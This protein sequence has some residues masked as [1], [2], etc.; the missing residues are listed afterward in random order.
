MS[1][2]QQPRDENVSGGERVGELDASTSRPV[3]RR[4]G[5]GERVGQVAPEPRGGR[6]G[7]VEAGLGTEKAR[8]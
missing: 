2:L 5:S 7:G 6:D 8:A 4:C 1:L 3:G